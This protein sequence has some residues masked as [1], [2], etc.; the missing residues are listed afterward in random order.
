MRRHSGSVRR[1]D[2]ITAIWERGFRLVRTSGKH[3]TWSNGTAVVA[4]PRTLKDAG[5]VRRIVDMVL[6]SAEEA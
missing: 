4:I 3:E 6:A 5:T 2:L 1:R